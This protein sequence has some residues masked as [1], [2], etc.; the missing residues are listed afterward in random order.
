MAYI[1]IIIYN[2]MSFTN[3]KY[4]KADC[5]IMSCIQNGKVIH[6]SKPVINILFYPL[7]H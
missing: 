6:Y 7:Y 1:M 5:Q 2:V 4:S 3:S